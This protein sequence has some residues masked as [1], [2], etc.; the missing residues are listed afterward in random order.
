MTVGLDEVK[1]RLRTFAA[2]EAAEVSPLYEH[3]AT[4]AAE[5]DEVAGLLT[6]APDETAGATLL[7]AAAHRLIQADPIHPLSRYYPS[8]GGFDGVDTQTWPVFREFLLERADKARAIIAVRHTETNEVSRAAGLYPAVALAA[9]QAGGKVAL[10]EIGCS[11]GLLLGLDKFGYRYQCDGGEQ[12]A[13]GP[14]KAAVGLHCALR[15]DAGAVPPKLPKKIAVGAK[16]GLDREVVDVSDED[17]LAWMEACVWADQLDRIRLLRTAAAAQ[18]KDA[19]DLVTGDAVDDLDAVAARAGEL[20]LIVI[21]S[22]L[23]WHLEAERRAGFVGALAKL[24]ADRPV[25]WVSDEPYEAGLAHVLP[26]RDELAF[27]DTGHCTL[28]L[29]TW[30]DG[31]AEALALAQTSR[32]GQRMTWLVS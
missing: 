18:R 21:T 20:P 7:L 26:G 28:G 32:F 1:R 5:D 9:K 29:V 16:I 2:A 31:K 13:A 3:L 27:V 25:W 17:E 15:L 10:L 22:R 23:L 24:G 11:A 14:A 12:I 4:N 6:E 30:R 19:P 8:L